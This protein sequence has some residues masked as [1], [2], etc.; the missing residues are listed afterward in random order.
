MTEVPIIP[1]EE[2]TLG[3]MT[4]PVP[5]GDGYLLLRFEDTPVRVM[6]KRI[7][8]STILL[9]AVVGVIIGLLH[10]REQ[11]HRP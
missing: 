2:G 5:E 3:R 11:S 1:E 9:L 10:R 4:V 7:T 8:W 6:G